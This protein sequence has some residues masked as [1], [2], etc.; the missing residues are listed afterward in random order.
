MQ[1]HQPYGDRTPHTWV[2]PSG[3]FNLLSSSST[4]TFI[5]CF[6]WCLLC[7]S[8]WFFYRSFTCSQWLVYQKLLVDI[9]SYFTWSTTFS[10]NVNSLGR[11]H[12]KSETYLLSGLSRESNSFGDRQPLTLM[13]NFTKRTQPNQPTTNHNP[14]KPH[15]EGN[16]RGPSSFL[17]RSSEIQRVT[18]KSV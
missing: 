4:K 7:T 11:C 2:L 18:V 6:I 15:S 13:N 5:W 8:Y 16:Q 12:P 14:P 3:N 17:I 10:L 1:T 9:V